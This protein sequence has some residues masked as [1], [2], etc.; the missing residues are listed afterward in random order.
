LVGKPKLLEI[1][2]VV[3]SDACESR[4]CLAQGREGRRTSSGPPRC[5]AR[6]P[7]EL[8]RAAWYSDGTKTICPGGQSQ[9]H[10]EKSC[11]NG[12]VLK[13]AGV[14]ARLTCVWMQAL[15]CTAGNGTRL[16]VARHTNE[17]LMFSH[18]HHYETTKEAR[19][20]ARRLWGRSIMGMCFEHAVITERPAAHPLEP[21]AR[22]GNCRLARW[23]A[24]CNA[25]SC[26]SC[27]GGPLVRCEHVLS[28]SCLKK[29]L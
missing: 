1:R 16:V 13:R 25:I 28:P 4:A 27:T 5:C 14:I 6:R 11:H 20:S 7:S 21:R 17:N 10:C 9:E 24:P 29:G 22:R 8:G 15:V 26:G 3:R 2:L 19:R 23:A 18:H 12:Y